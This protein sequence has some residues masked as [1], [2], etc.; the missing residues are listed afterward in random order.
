MTNQKHHSTNIGMNQTFKALLPFNGLV[1]LMFVKGCLR[2]FVPSLLIKPWVTEVLSWAVDIF[3]V[4]FLFFNKMKMQAHSMTDKQQAWWTFLWKTILIIIV[5]DAI[6]GLSHQT[7]PY[8]IFSS[9]LMCLLIT[10]WFVYQVYLFK[11]RRIWLLA[12]DEVYSHQPL[13]LLALLKR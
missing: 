12:V 3:L 11:N 6:L 13:L 4:W 9:A 7:S 2:L 8:R 5:L 10:I 1:L